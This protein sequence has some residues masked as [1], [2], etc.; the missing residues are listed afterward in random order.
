MNHIRRLVAALFLVGLALT[1]L[2]HASASGPTSLGVSGWQVYSNLTIYPNP[3]PT[4]LHGEPGEYAAAP[5]IPA[6]N[7]GGWANCGA[8]APLRYSPYQGPRS[9]C[10]SPSTIGMA[11]GSILSDCFAHLNFTY[12]QALVSIPAGTT[13]SSFTVN[14]HGADDGARISLVNSHYPNGV[15]PN[16]GAYIWQN[17]GQATGDLS[18]YVVA[19]EVNRVV[20]TQ[21]DDCAVG[22][23]LNY[24]QIYLN[25]TVIPPDTTAPTTTATPTGPTKNSSGWYTGPVSVALAATDPDD[26]VSK[27]A[28]TLDGT[29][30]SITGST[31]SVQVSGDGVHTLTYAATDSHTNTESTKSL[32]VKIDST[33]PSVSCA[34]PSTAWSASDVTAACTASDRASGLATPGQSSTTLTTSVAAGTANGNASTNSITV[35]DVAGNCATEGPYTGLKVDKQAPTAIVTATYGVGPSTY[36]SGRW[37]NTN[38]TV[39]VTC[40]DGTGSGAANPTNTQVVSTEGPGQ[41]STPVTCRDN[42]G[43]TASPASFSGISIDKTPPTIHH[44]I[45][46]PSTTGWYTIATGAPI[47]A[48]SCTDPANASNGT[49]GS[50]LASCSPQYTFAEGAN[51]SVTGTA[52]DNAGNTSTD[53]ITGVNVDLTRPTITITGVSDGANYNASVT[54]V[55]TLADPNGAN[56]AAGSGVGAS[57]ITLDGQPY[58]SGTAVTVLGPHTLTVSVSDVAGNSA[59]P[60]TIH[61]LVYAF[62]STGNFVIADKS[63][64]TW[65]HNTLTNSGDQTVYFFG[66]QWEKMQQWYNYSTSESDLHSFKGFVD[67]TG[68]LSCMQN[69]TSQLEK[70]SRP[71]ATLPSY[72]AVLVSHYLYKQSDRTII[73]D[74]PMIIIVKTNPGY[75]SSPDEGSDHGSDGKANPGHAGTG[76]YV[77]TLCGSTANPSTLPPPTNDHGNSGSNSGPGTPSGSSDNGGDQGGSTSSNP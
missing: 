36:V 64:D 66:S 48:W 76:T 28:Y 11:V 63:A 22:N 21:V 47:A 70:S 37:V 55:I 72:M 44:A 15:S 61:F 29:P 30:G 57:S 9:L 67:Q 77:S 13:I 16:P 7:D 18:S 5:S 27:I 51:Q 20:I 60:Q 45:T 54:P 75:S 1:P 17:T 53:T 6:Q 68:P 52:A 33:A 69:Y 73:G 62:P 4:H 59:T 32:T 14:M 46:A 56:G 31:G 19:G 38:V 35:C 26:A 41:S 50:G 39:T 49:A 58:T 23:N 34:A 65:I 43:N 8:S 10:P 42:V 3:D 40:N 74:I 2:T 71:P 12:F 25:G 24:A